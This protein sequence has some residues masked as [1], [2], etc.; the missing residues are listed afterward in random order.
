MKRA[1]SKIPELH[2]YDWS[3]TRWFTSDTH[4]ILDATGRGIYRELLD[5]CYAQGRIP[6]D[7]AIL[8][9]MCRS[10][11]IQFADVWPLIKR[12]FTADKNDG[13]YLRNKLAD[14][15]RSRYFRY[16]KTQREKA[17][18]GGRENG[19]T[20]R[21]VNP[22][23][24]NVPQSSGLAVASKPEK[25]ERSLKEKKRKLQSTSEKHSSENGTAN[26]GGADPGGGVSL[27]P[28]DPP[29]SSL[30]DD[31][32]EWFGIFF[33]AGVQ[34]SE[35]D[36]IMACRGTANTLGLLQYEPPERRQI[37]AYTLDKAKRVEARHLGMPINILGRQEWRR[38]GGERI[39]PVAR[40]PSKSEQ[41]TRDA[42]QIFLEGKYGAERERQS[43]H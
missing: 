30:P 32:Q 5:R 3:L 16:K 22:N 41:A 9:R 20:P 26:T 42:A 35:A 27:A 31:A 36:M 38:R 33:A 39:L 6:S 24:V 7:P 29:T 17:A 11:D 15:F 10:T 21:A 19:K 14:T 43:D 28:I 18:R 2:Y 37:I 13:S 34:L 1:D 23:D 8:A 25:P 40:E 4:D 12:H